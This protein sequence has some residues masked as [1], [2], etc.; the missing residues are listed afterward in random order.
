VLFDVHRCSRADDIFFI[1]AGLGQNGGAWLARETF[2][3]TLPG[4]VAHRAPLP[5]ASCT[6]VIVAR[7]LI[8]EQHSPT[9][10]LEGGRY[11]A[12][13]PAM[14]TRPNCDQIAATK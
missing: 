6:I 14:D 7:A 3:P 11:T 8:D 2:V 1:E 9:R 10:C 4:D 12:I 13:R 5:L